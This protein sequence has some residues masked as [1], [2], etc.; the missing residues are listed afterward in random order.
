MVLVREAREEDIPAITAIYAHYVRNE[1]ASFEIDPPDAGE[2]ARRWAGVR[3]QGLPYLVAESGG[4]IAGYAY[5][6][7]YRPRKAYRFTV[8]HSIY[9]DPRFARQG[10][11]A[12]LMK[13][14]MET[15]ER[16]GY[17]Q[18]IAVIGGSENTASIRFHSSLGFQHAGTLRGVG[19]K[20]GRWLDSVLMQR[21]M[22]DTAG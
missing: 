22:G 4:E 6:V 9:V 2:M 11:G 13:P 12:A 10:V 21:P 15:C 5:V 20:F 19:F 7:P 8:E 16:L 14:L 3:E 17:R 18:M 1:T